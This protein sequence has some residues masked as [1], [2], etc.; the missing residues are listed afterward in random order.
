M[1]FSLK[2]FANFTFWGELEVV[3]IGDT[4]SDL[5]LT[6][7]ALDAENYIE[8]N[9]GYLTEYVLTF[10]PRVKVTLLKILFMVDNNFIDSIKLT[11]SLIKV[12][13]NDEKIFDKSINK[14]FTDNNYIIW[15]YYNQYLLNISLGRID[16]ASKL[17]DDFEKILD[18]YKPNVE[19]YDGSAV[20]YPL[21]KILIIP[22]NN[23]KG[24]NDLIHYN[25]DEL[26]DEELKKIKDNHKNNT[27][28]K[29]YKSNYD[30]DYEVL[31][32]YLIN[33]ILNNNNQK[34]LLNWSKEK[35]INLRDLRIFYINTLSNLIY[36][37]DGSFF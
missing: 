32:S 21:S 12:F 31:N 17:Q 4:F 35:N 20:K 11:D 10:Y 19:S 13:D 24:I 2:N 29:L 27:I 26:D 25:V 3:I 9:A 14:I 16:V 33:Y 18:K 8:K 28:L 22:E 5:L 37:G 23:E 7:I 36:D 34:R 15:V 6:S 1:L 30:N